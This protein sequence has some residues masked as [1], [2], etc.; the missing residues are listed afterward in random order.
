MNADINEA[1]EVNNVSNGTL[2][3]HIGLKVGY[4]KHVGRKHGC[5][6]IVTDISAGLLKLSDNIVKSRLTAAKLTSELR[7]AVLLCFK[8]EKSEIIV[9][10]VIG[11]KLESV[12]KLLCNCV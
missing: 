9:L 10:Y 2:K 3:L 7:N 11:G 1:T 12:K 8:S 5:G 4:L 6:C